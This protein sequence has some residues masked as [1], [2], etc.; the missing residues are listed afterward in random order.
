M[1]ISLTILL[2]L[3]TTVGFSQ[4]DTIRPDSIE[5]CWYQQIFNFQLLN[6]KYY[7]SEPNDSTL[8]ESDSLIF[9]PAA[10]FGN[11]SKGTDYIDS[12]RF[13]IVSRTLK[14]YQE[15]ILYNKPLK[16]IRFIWLKYQTPIILTL[17]IS[18]D[19]VKLIYKE[20]DG[21]FDIHGKVINEKIST[22]SSGLFTKSIEIFN[23]SDFFN[24]K[25]GITFC[26]ND[27]I[28][29]LEPT[30]FVESYNGIVY[31]TI[32]INE[33]NLDFDRFEYIFKAFRKILKNCK[34]KYSP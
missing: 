20:C 14:F 25:H 9:E 31:N 26:H 30:F 19:T 27:T 8:V 1:K 29:T 28:P 22:F 3:F 6:R 12:V 15:P 21:S 4:K 5:Y 2:I 34:I 13:A 32:N 24:L 23:R 17:Y 11:F 33:C 18:K 16:F 7:F 10:Y